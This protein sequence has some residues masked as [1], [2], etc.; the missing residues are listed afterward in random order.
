MHVVV[1]V[2]I[3]AYRITIFRYGWWRYTLVQEGGWTKHQDVRV[4]L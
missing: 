2:I 1:L 4:C 3:A